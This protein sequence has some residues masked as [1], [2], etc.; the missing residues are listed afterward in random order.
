MTNP[1]LDDFIECPVKAMKNGYYPDIMSCLVLKA[2]FLSWESFKGI[3][4]SF[5]GL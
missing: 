1:T 4:T 2:S 5:F 3:K